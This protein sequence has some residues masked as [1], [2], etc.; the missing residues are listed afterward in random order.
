LVA[1]YLGSPFFP[2]K[3]LAQDGDDYFHI[4][5]IIILITLEDYSKSPKLNIGKL[6]I[7][8]PYSY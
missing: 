8:L 5:S 3:S 6:D 1:D 4:S 7:L 2:L